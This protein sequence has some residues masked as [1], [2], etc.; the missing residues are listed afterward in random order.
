VGSGIE[1]AIPPT[2]HGIEPPSDLSVTPLVGDVPFLFN[3][4]PSIYNHGEILDLVVFYNKNFG[5]T[6]DDTLGDRAT[7]FISYCKDI[8]LYFRHVKCE[9]LSYFVEQFRQHTEN[10]VHLGQ[11]G[12]KDPIPKAYI[13]HCVPSVALR[14]LLFYMHLSRSSLPL[15]LPPSPVT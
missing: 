15:P 11:Q 4:D 6:I 12:V 9:F 1:L 7:K 14:C 3:P 13:V 10:E 8:E 5:I 2:P